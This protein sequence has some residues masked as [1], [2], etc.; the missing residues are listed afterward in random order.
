MRIEI[1]DI[2]DT[3]EHPIEDVSQPAD[4]LIKFKF[5]LPRSPSAYQRLLLAGG[6]GTR[7]ILPEAPNRAGVQGN[8][9][10][11]SRIYRESFEAHRTS[12]LFARTGIV[13]PR[14]LLRFN[15]EHFCDPGV[16][17]TN[18][19]AVMT[20]VCHGPRLF[21]AVPHEAMR[22]Y[23]GFPSEV[24][25]FTRLDPGRVQVFGDFQ[26]AETWIRRT[27]SQ[28]R[29]RGVPMR[30]GDLRRTLLLQD[31]GL[32]C[33]R[34]R[35]PRTMIAHFNPREERLRIDDGQEPY[36]FFN[37][38]SLDG[39]RAETCATCTHF[40]FSGMSRDMS[41]G[42]SGY[43]WLRSERA[44]TSGL[45]ARGRDVEPSFH[46]SVSVDDTCDGHSFIEDSAR[47]PPYGV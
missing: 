9:D 34:G 2:L 46:T 36:A 4:H 28:L 47:Q 6:T 17:Y 41:D 31:A 45:P 1:E 13:A 23:L 40:R 16:V 10:T 18:G 5:A 39:F 44:S 43:C 15:I 3:Q 30:R 42:S 25:C 22:E 21:S 38:L 7:S 26:A 19:Q 12:V 11:M 20:S 14:D 35:G 27:L 32:R 24:E 37:R 33:S 8:F 29:V